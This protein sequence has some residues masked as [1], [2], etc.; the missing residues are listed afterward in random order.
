MAVGD[1]TY[2]NSVREQLLAGRARLADVV[3]DNESE[4]MTRL[5]AEVDSA[6]HRIDHG[7]FGVCEICQGVVEEESLRDNPLARVC[8][9][10]LTPKQQRALEYDLELAAQIQKGLLPPDDVSIAGWGISYHHKPAGVVSGD[11][12]D[13]IDHDGKLNFVMADVSGKGVAAAMLASNLRAIFRSLIPMGFPLGELM[14]RANRLFRESTLPTQY[15]TMVVGR[16][17][18]SGNLE[19]VNAG[20]LPV[21]QLGDSGTKVFEST[22]QP[23]GVFSDQKFSAAQSRLEPGDTLV[24]YTDGICEAVNDGGDEYGMDRLRRLLEENRLHC[25]VEMVTACRKHLEAFRGSNERLD[26]E[27]L[28]A[29]Q[30]TPAAQAM[31]S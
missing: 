13:L 23:L 7:S 17:S 21:L 19:V 28:L 6:L 22:A 2:V 15:A 24:M 12:C 4:H 1:T 18:S 27:T 25:P 3:G 30:Y 9:D 20:H 29:I 31:A 8:L 5:L 10:C 16:A 11:Y 26:D 14:A